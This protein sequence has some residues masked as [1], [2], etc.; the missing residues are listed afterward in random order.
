[1]YDVAIIGG[2]I[3]GASAAAFL[4]EAGASAVLFEQSQ[5]A[6]AASGRN[7]GV[8]QHPYDPVLARLH[9]ESLELYRQLAADDGQFNVGE[10]PAGVLLVSR[11]EE[12]V[13]ETARR[14]ALATPELRPLPIPAGRLRRLEPTLAEDVAGCILQTGY[15]VVPAAATLAFARRATRAGAQ[16]RVNAGA[17][18]PI[19]ADGRAIGVV[20]EAGEQ[21][22]AGSVLVAAGPWTPPLVPGWDERPPIYATWGV[23]VSVRLPAAPTA[24]LEEL[25]IDPTGLG[26]G[27]SFSLVTAG[28]V[29]SVGSTF[30]AE[31]PEPEQL[32]GRLIAR[33]STFV[34]AI[35]E[36]VDEG[37]RLCAR[38][39]S[40]DGRPLIGP[41]R[42]V[43]G[44]FVCAG[45]GPW[46]MSTGPASARLVSSLI[47][48]RNND[49]LAPAALAATRF[50]A[51]A[52]AG[53]EL[54]SAAAL[55]SRR[56]RA[57]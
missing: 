16:L 51:S 38:P 22:R 50:S 20:T 55:P 12:A 14:L 49:V 36:A 29:S 44:L 56:G 42:G 46:G 41:V 53:R 23:V 3:I 8:L 52:E 27:I 18:R 48:D 33:A 54:S 31:R 1:M 11:G 19:V 30:L 37:V 39:V 28:G 32:R 15:P 47:L 43:D 5:I 7:S 57:G 2:G 10:A 26:E 34:P 9:A 25:D 24:V 21:V 35:A 17:A 4:A 40:F 45:H 13:H 6:A